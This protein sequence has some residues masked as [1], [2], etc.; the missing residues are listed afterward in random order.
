[1]LQE[2]TLQYKQIEVQI[3]P[4]EFYKEHIA[5]FKGELEIWY[6]QNLSFYTDA[7]LIFLTAWVIIFPKS[8]LVNKVF[9]NLPERP[10]ELG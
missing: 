6:Q 8:N 7:M 10:K 1:M 2:N 5:P 3:P 4:H 9:K